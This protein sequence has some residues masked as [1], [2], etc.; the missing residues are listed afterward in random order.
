[1]FLK[2]C[3]STLIVY[4][5]GGSWGA[6]KIP[7]ASVV[8]VRETPLAG[9]TILTVAPATAELLLSLTCPVIEPSLWPN[10][11]TASAMTIASA[12]QNLRVVILF[13]MCFLR[14]RT[15]GCPL[16]EGLRMARLMNSSVTIKWLGYE[17]SAGP[18]TEDNLRYRARRDF[19]RFRTSSKT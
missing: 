17:A 5:P 11:T 16:C 8:I 10:A 1:T 2:P 4:A 19:H 14:K 7:S 9:L 18:R 6:T 3:L 15:A 12:V 13:M